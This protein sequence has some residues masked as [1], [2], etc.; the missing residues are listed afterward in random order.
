M[1]A[2]LVEI[3]AFAQVDVGRRG[4]S[5]DGW[6]GFPVTSPTGIVGIEFRNIEKKR[7]VKHYLPSAAW[8][9]TWIGTKDY[10]RKCFEGS[11]LWVVE[12]VFDLFALRWAIPHPIVSASKAYFTSRQR[13]FIERY[14]RH[15]VRFAL[16]NDEFGKK[17]LHGEGEKQ[18]LL[19]RLEWSGVRDVVAV[20]YSGKDPGDVWNKGGE[21]SIIA[22]FE[23]WR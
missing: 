4:E 2:G 21:R 7:I 22:Q 8:G 18:G 9:P 10:T 5:V 12:G 15:G 3:P 6:V 1:R 16:D 11:P 20:R 23:K 17:S 19:A 13:V 14:A